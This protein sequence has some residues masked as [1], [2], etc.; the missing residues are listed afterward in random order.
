MTGSAGGAV[1]AHRRARRPWA[2]LAVAVVPALLLVAAELV[3]R[4]V[5][6]GAVRSL[7]IEQLE[8]PSDQ[9]LDVT[10]D[11][12]LLPQL[13]TGTLDEVTLSSDEVTLGGVTGAARVTAYGVPLHGGAL[14]S[15]TGTVAIDQ[16]GLAALLAGSPLPDVEISLEAPDVV[17]SGEI[18]VLGRVIPL[19]VTVT[20]A[21]EDGD[22]LLTPVSAMLGGSELDVQALS[23]RLGPVG[24]RLAGPQRLCI[25][26]HLP[27]GVAVTGLHIEGALAVIDI[28]A[29]GRIAV[30]PVLLE[31]GTCSR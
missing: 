27:A 3:A 14:R 30:D 18:T 7:V 28:R 10:A 17:L 29:D 31:N 19:K 1:G 16:S 22:L 13:V 20:P 2:V 15:A 5:L 4:T 11:G 12:V 25:A 23:R 26:E 6:P 24:E 9:Q 21:A 8:L